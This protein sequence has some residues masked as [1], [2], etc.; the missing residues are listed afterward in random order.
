MKLRR[1]ERGIEQVGL[2]IKVLMAVER[3]DQLS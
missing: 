2:E 3:M 1:H